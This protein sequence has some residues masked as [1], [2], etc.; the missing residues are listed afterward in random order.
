[1]VLFYCTALDLTP[2]THAFVAD[3]VNGQHHEIGSRRRTPAAGPV[4]RCWYLVHLRRDV[5]FDRLAAALLVRS[6]DRARYITQVVAL[7]AQLSPSCAGR[8]GSRSA[9]RS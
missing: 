7:L 4:K 9:R 8:R 6:G 1:M 2:A 3:L 5:A